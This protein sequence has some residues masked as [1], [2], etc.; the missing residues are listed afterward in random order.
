MVT[1]ENNNYTL[2][3]SGIGL[4]VSVGIRS[5]IVAIYVPEEF[6]NQT[7][8]LLGNYNEVKE[9]DFILPDGT[10]LSNTLNDRQLHQQFGNACKSLSLVL[11]RCY[12]TCFFVCLCLCPSVA[13]SASVSS[14]LF[15]VSSLS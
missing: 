3:H 9:D 10:V 15:F 2:L 6:R 13:P 5:L 4:S 11:F 12:I 7:K 14:L 1:G 8:G